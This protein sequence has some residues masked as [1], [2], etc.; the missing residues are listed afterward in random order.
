MALKESQ[1]VGCLVAAGHL[2]TYSHCAPSEDL[3]DPTK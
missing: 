2:G 3:I 1:R